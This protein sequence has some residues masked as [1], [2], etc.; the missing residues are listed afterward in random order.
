MQK[1]NLLT[2]YQEL[3]SILN[4]Q[5]FR[6]KMRFHGKIEENEYDIVDEHHPELTIMEIAEN[7]NAFR[8]LIQTGLLKKDVCLFCGNTPVDGK[9]TFTEPVN[10]TKLNICPDCHAKGR[11]IQGGTGSGPKS[12][13]LSVIVILLSLTFLTT[14][15]IIIGKHL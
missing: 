4:Q 3:C 12:G 6:H 8:Y 10:S 9:Y 15:G 14:I 11:I 1:I 7:S 13:C 5:G 2:Y